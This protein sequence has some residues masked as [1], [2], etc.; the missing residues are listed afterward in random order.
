MHGV[1]GSAAASNRAPSDNR[2]RSRGAVEVLSGAL[3]WRDVLW[4]RRWLS[5]RGFGRAGAGLH[6][7]EDQVGEMTTSNVVVMGSFDDVRS[8]DIRFLE[9]AAQLGAVRVLLWADEVVR[10]VT[11][12]PP[13][14]PLAERSYL[15]Q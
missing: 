12:L 5:L 1:L 2:D 8:R 10:A 13:K 3:R 6:A 11:G 7:R 14:F 4:L 15:L 9:E